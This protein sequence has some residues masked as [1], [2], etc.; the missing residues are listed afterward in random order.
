MRTKLL[1][2]AFTTLGM[3]ACEMLPTAFSEDDLIPDETE[4]SVARDGDEEGCWYLI[5][6]YIDTREIIS[7]TNLGCSHGG[8]GSNNNL[9]V[10]FNCDKDITRG[11]TGGCSITTNPYN[12]TMSGTWT[13]N[14]DDG[15]NTTQT[16]SH[17]SFRGTAVVS[18][19]MS[20]SGTVSHS[21]ESE[22]VGTNVRITV[23]A[24]TNT[25]WTKGAARFHNNGPA[26]AGTLDHCVRSG[27]VTSD[28]NSPCSDFMRV[29]TP[30]VAQGTGPWS[31]IYFIRSHNSSVN[32]A[33]Q[34]NR[35]FRSDKPKNFMTGDLRDDCEGTSAESVRQNELT[36]NALACA[37]P[38]A[39]NGALGHVV[40]HER[41]HVNLAAAEWRSLDL[42][43]GIEAI[44]AI[45]ASLARSR[46]ETS[47]YN[48]RRSL[49]NASNFHTGT[50]NDY[51]YWR[52][53]DGF[54]W[55]WDTQRLYN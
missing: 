1:L 53:P 9:Y 45:N 27:G 16:G 25:T 5:I 15:R 23:D 19:S 49:W 32:V 24:R 21:G 30:S 7:R 4:S 34:I 12:A 3:L 22:S 54:L 29:G 52:R 26:A 43:E 35:E 20:Y 18:G 38:N 2:A 13:F 46:A 14:P 51:S 47:L 33:I 10:T 55:R 8:G 6:Y 37:R 31:G 36:A 39:F 17:K 42:F 11:R 28:T 40:S 50:Y 41:K 48:G 44:V